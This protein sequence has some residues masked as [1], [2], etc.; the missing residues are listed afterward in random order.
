SA[1]HAATRLPPR[2]VDRNRAVAL[3]RSDRSGT[4]APAGRRARDDRRLGGA[5]RAARRVRPHPIR[6]RRA[7]GLG[8]ACVAACDAAGASVT[9]EIGGAR[10]I[11]R[12][13]RT[14]PEGR[15]LR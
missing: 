9:P 10:A 11:A 7:L 1:G 12:T 6:R 15:G 2:G 4:L 8:G 14:F 5:D 3:A 13:P